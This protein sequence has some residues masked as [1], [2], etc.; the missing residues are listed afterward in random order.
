MH[1]KFL[2]MVVGLSLLLQVISI[3]LA[4]RLIKVTGW[5]NAWIFLS[6]GIM[7][8][9][10]RRLMNFI[11]YTSGNVIEIPEMQFEVIGLVGS[12]LMLI[13]VMFI[14]PIFQALKNVEKIQSEALRDKDI[15]MKE[16]YH[17][18]K[19][20]L[21]VIQS[22]LSLQMREIKDEQHKA[23]FVD[24]QNRVKSMTMIHERL[25]RSE[26]LKN[27]GAGEYIRS[28]SDTLFHNYRTK[29]NVRLS[30]N[31][32]DVRV[33]VDTMIP[34]GL[35]LNEL[36]SNSLKYAFP[37]GRS[38]EL[39]ISFIKPDEGEYELV[40][41]DNGIGLPKDFDIRQ[42]KS[43]GLTIVTSLASQLGGELSVSVENGAEFRI[44]FRDRAQ[45]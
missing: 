14:G 24:I 11:H 28:L 2:I 35:I 18:V 23:Y 7:T 40:V 36:V 34:L 8:M 13:G 39:H 38:G 44:R 21:A 42:S 29:S 5:K 27:I 45:A 32:Q 6:I 20:N 17:R 12:S 37:D 22:L 1:N 3:I 19:N 26:D 15:L 25:H 33:D 41:R 4:L 31:L 30:Y 10:V 9:G 16:I 43:L